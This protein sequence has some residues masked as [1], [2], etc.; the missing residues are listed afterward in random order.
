MR[1]KGFNGDAVYPEDCKAM[2]ETALNF[3]GCLNVLVN[4][5]G[6]GLS[7]S[8]SNTSRS[9]GITKIDDREWDDALDMK[10]KSAMLASRVSIPEISKTGGC[11]IINIS[12]CDAFF[13]GDH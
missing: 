3:Y 11:S 7:N 5:I 10:L 2:I 6:F 8:R 9:V 4:N 13:S 1:C 12:S